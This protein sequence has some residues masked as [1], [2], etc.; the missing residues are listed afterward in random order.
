MENVVPGFQVS[1]K[2]HMQLNKNKTKKN[3]TKNFLLASKNVF[4]VTELQ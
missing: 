4:T 2:T 3:P 1:L